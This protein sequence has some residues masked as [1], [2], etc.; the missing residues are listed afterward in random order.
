M[1]FYGEYVSAGE[2]RARAK[3]EV[4][5]L[6]RL[7]KSIEPVVIEG[8]ALA[9]NFWGQRWCSHLES[10][11]DFSNRLPRGRTY[12]RNGSVCH[13]EIKDGQVEALVHGSSMY[14]IQV[15]IKPLDD[16]IWTSVKTQCV[17][18]IET[19]LELLAGH[20]SKQVM[21]VVAHRHEGLYPLPKEIAFQCDCPDGA[22][23]C[24][25]I[26]AVLYGV[27]HRLDSRPELLF[28]LRG[29]D[30]GELL[31]A[32]LALPSGSSEDLL[33]DDRLAD[34]FGIELDEDA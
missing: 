4:D 12:V 5:K 30:A 9:K 21:E 34:I 26:A 16:R 15:D 6:L 33:D 27:G 3:R 24:K 22:R 19:M 1:A 11:S 23:M 20:F 13:L 17:G 14:K 28:L 10:F 18:R 29:V 2:R 7:G 25:H 31:G 32:P 8:R